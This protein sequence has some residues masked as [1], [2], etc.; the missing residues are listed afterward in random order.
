M[1]AVVEKLKATVDS[2]RNDSPAVV[3]V[4]NVTKQLLIMTLTVENET[5]VYKII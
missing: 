4:L 5:I 1:F 3:T 2:K